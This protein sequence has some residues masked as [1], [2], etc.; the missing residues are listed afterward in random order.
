MKTQIYNLI[1]P[2]VQ[3]K[4]INALTIISEVI[5]STM[6]P[7][8][9]TCIL[10]NG[11]NTPHVTKDG[12]TVAEFLKF[13]DT[14]TEAI[15]MLVKETAHK[16]AEAVGD[17]TTT[18]VLLACKMCIQ[19]LQSKNI[20]ESMVE[21]EKDLI[22][23]ID[24]I[25]KATL[26]LD[27]SNKQEQL[28][29][30]RSI[31]HI[32]SNGD[33]EITELILTTLQQVG[34]DG[35]IDVIPAIGSI[36]ET[37]TREGMLIESPAMNI[38]S[39]VD[40][41][42]PQILL[43]AGALDK[44]TQF[45]TCMQIANGLFIASNVPVI[46]IAKEFSKEIQN[47]VLANNRNSKFLMYLVESDGFANGALEILDDMSNVLQCKIMSSDNTSPYAIQ[48]VTAQD[49]VSVGAAT[50][51]P[52]NTVLYPTHVLSEEALQIKREII[53]SIEAIKDSGE[54]VIGTLSHLHRRLSKFSKSA[55]I[56]IGGLTDADKL[57]RKDR[58]DD[59]VNALYAAIKG[60]VVAGGGSTL[61]NAAN[62]SSCGVIMQD[63]CKTPALKLYP[64]KTIEELNTIFN[65]GNV[66]DGITGVIGGAKVLGILD[67]ADVQ[68]KSIQ[69]ALAITKTIV[70]T[71]II[72]IPAKDAT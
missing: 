67:P 48:N 22:S 14:F 61:F 6:G 19:V 24:Y 5:T 35:L 63:V 41:T 11:V 69:Q 68:I 57:E 65:E 21:L 46:I 53:N 54:A 50:I 49:F 26:I 59:A 37:I 32:S 72:L 56:R 3:N 27:S 12:V 66:I 71:N 45:K 43:V 40:L 13:E 52:T 17:G 8:G 29:I 34:V 64:N 25:N 44:V 55:T 47:I 31:V 2:D 20:P 42:D 10:Y 4:L 30:L 62:N 7:A 39:T 23:I 36:T 58:V 60:G 15:N 1:K 28:D 70:N 38:N 18:S 16:T 9:K 33:T 51:T